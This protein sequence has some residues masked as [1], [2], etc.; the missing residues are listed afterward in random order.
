MSSRSRCRSGC[1]ARSGPRSS[2]PSR[3]SMAVTALGNSGATPARGHRGRGDRLRQRRRAR[4]G[5]RRQ[6][7]RQDRLHHPCHGADA[8]RIGLRPVRRAARARVRRSP[9]RKGA[10]AIVIRSIGTDHHRNPHTGVQSFGRGRPA[11]PGRRAF[12]PRRRAAPAHPRPR[13][14][15]AD[16]ADP[17]AAQHRPRTVRQCRRRGAGQRSRPPASI[18]DR[19]PSRQLG[20]RHRRDRQCR[21]RRDHHRGGAPDHAGRAA[22]AHD[23]RR[24]VRRRGGRRRRR[25]DP[26]RAQPGGGQRRPGRRI[27]FRRRPGLAGRISAW[28]RPTPRSATAIAA[29]LAPLGIVRGRDRANAGADLGN[30]AQAG[31]A[32]IDLNQDGTR[33]FDYHHTPDDTLDKVDPAQLRQN[34]AAWTAMLA[35]VADAPE[36]IAP[37]EATR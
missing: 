29:L 3:S 2:R 24:P 12:H 17:H 33:Y 19:R 4:G 26:F 32:A 10:A 22:A 11:D 23:P 35:A 13:P 1:A 6:R 34:V 27:R 28:R 37:T 16:A 15:G 30:W 20:S 9:S 25:R 18:V 14:A 31:T 8:G 7:A 5:A 36:A 21:R